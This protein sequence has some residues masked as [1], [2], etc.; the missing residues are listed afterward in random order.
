[1]ARTVSN[2][3]FGRDVCLDRCTRARYR[4][5]LLLRLRRGLRHYRAV[6]R[7]YVSAVAGYDTAAGPQCSA[8]VAGPI[9]EGALDPRMA[10]A[11]PT[12]RCG[13]RVNTQAAARC[14]R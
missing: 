8:V 7:W 12:I 2:G 5:P 4:K 1:M 6:S 14:D 13:G 11:A 3:P 9:I 10:A